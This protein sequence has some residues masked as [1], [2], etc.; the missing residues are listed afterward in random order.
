MPVVTTPNPT[1]H[2]IPR[3]KHKLRVLQQDKK[4]QKI[5]DA[6]DHAKTMH[7]TNKKTILDLKIDNRKDKKASRIVICEVKN[8][9]S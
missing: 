1:K 2:P 7:G 6:L 9:R 8:S 5:T 3:W 4:I